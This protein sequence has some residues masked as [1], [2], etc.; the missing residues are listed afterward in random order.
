MKTVRELLPEW[1]AKVDKEPLMLALV[2]DMLE[3]EADDVAEAMF[4]VSLRLANIFGW[5]ATF[6]PERPI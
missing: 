3:Y 4:I 2:K 5:V 6:K 1:A